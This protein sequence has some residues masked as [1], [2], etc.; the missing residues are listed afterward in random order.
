[1]AMCSQNNPSGISPAAEA[2]TMAH[3]Q[4][5]NQGLQQLLNDVHSLHGLSVSATACTEFCSQCLQVLK[6]QRIRTKV[7]YGGL[8]KKGRTPDLHLGIDTQRPPRCSAGENSILNGQ[9]ICRKPFC[10]PSSRLHIICQE[11][12]KPAPGQ[13]HQLH[14]YVFACSSAILLAVN[15]PEPRNECSLAGE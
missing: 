9:V 13:V 3:I 11:L 2:R 10:C 15:L 7:K 6:R 5:P 14:S 8:T 4:V 12:L 1:M